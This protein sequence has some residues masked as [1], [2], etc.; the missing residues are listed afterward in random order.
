MAAA[1]S[2]NSAKA[3]ASGEA[4]HLHWL[5]AAEQLGWCAARCCQSQGKLMNTVKSCPLGYSF[6]A[7]TAWKRIASET[8]VSTSNGSHDHTHFPWRVSHMSG[9]VAL[10]VQSRLAGLLA[11][12]SCAAR[13]LLWTWSWYCKAVMWVMRALPHEQLSLLASKWASYKLWNPGLASV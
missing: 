13:V 2:S 6:I 8:E 10:G 4:V 9:R 12:C 3:A 1:L 7:R 11:C 5:L